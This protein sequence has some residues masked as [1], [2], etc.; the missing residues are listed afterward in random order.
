MR[1]CAT[2]LLLVFAFA[3]YGA[4]WQAGAQAPAEP[5]Q[6]P[7][8]Q[9]PGDQGQQQPAEQGQQSPDQAQQPSSQQQSMAGQA[10]TSSISGCLLQAS[11]DTFALQT[12][13]GQVQLKAGDQLKSDD[14]SKH[15]GQEVRVTGD[16]SPAGTESAANNHG[17]SQLPQSDQP[18]AGENSQNRTFTANNIDM[19]DQTCTTSSMQE[20]APN[21]MH[22]GA[23][24]ENRGPE[25]NTPQTQPQSQPQPTQP[26]Y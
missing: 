23:T 25:D 11:A 14:I 26:G 2:T 10:E 17:A 8:A 21:G 20:G 15:V 6:S 5:S 7:S 4:A 19:V 22:P 16:W 13:Q 1:K 18:N 3:A 12:K 24:P 9:Q